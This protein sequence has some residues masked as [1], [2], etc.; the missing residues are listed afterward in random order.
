VRVVGVLIVDDQPF[1][2]GAARAVVS[3][4]PGFRTVAEASSGRQAVAVVDELRPD[5]VVLDVRMPDMDGIQTTRQIKAHRPE[6]VVIL[7]SVEDLDVLPSSGRTC[8]AEVLVDKR[9]FG[10]ALLRRVWARHGAG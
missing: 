5:V 9:E 8:G 2:R 10:P 6:T 1:F 3:S 7:V 4:L